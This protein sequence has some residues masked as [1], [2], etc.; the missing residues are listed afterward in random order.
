MP[1]YGDGSVSVPTRSWTRGRQNSDGSIESS[2][3]ANGCASS[4][5]LTL[6]RTSIA[7]NET[8]AYGSTLRCSLIAGRD[9]SGSYSRVD[10]I[11]NEKTGEMVK[12]QNPMHHS[13][14]RHLQWQLSYQ[15]MFSP[16]HEYIYWREIWLERV[17]TGD[18][19]VSQS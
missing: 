7:S 10:E 15:R 17:E 11:I 1:F 9:H 4:P 8:A 2:A 13:R 14:G 16:R 6:M 19:E 5:K 18:K 3:W 12:F